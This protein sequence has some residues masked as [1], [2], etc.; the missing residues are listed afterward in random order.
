MDIR[1]IY[2]APYDRDRSTNWNSISDEAEALDSIVESMESIALANKG[3]I[4]RTKQVGKDYKLDPST[5]FTRN[6]QLSRLILRFKDSKTPE[7]I[8]IY[9]FLINLAAYEANV[10]SKVKSN[11]NLISNLRE[12]AD[13]V[14]TMFTSIINALMAESQE[15][16]DFLEENDISYEEGFIPTTIGKLLQPNSKQA[17]DNSLKAILDAIEIIAPFIP[18]DRVNELN[19][20]DVLHKN[21]NEMKGFVNNLIN[22]IAALPQANDHKQSLEILLQIEDA[23][24]KGNLDL[25][26]MKTFVR[27]LPANFKPLKDLIEKGLDK[28]DIEQLVDEQQGLPS[29]LTKDENDKIFVDVNDFINQ[30]YGQVS[31]SSKDDTINSDLLEQVNEN[32]K[33]RYFGNVANNK[34]REHLKILFVIGDENPYTL[35]DREGY[36]VYQVTKDSDLDKLL[37]LDISKIDS[38]TT[39]A[40]EQYLRLIEYTGLTFKDGSEAQ[41]KINTLKEILNP[42]PKKDI[43]EVEDIEEVQ[44]EPKEEPKEESVD[45]G[46]SSKN[47]YD[48]SGSSEHIKTILKDFSSQKIFADTL[49]DIGGNITVLGQPAKLEKQLFLHPRDNTGDFLV[50]R[51]IDGDIVFDDI[52]RTSALQA[53]LELPPVQIESFIDQISIEDVDNFKKIMETAGVGDTL[54]VKYVRG[55]RKLKEEPPQTPISKESTPQSDEFFTPQLEIPQTPSKKSKR[56]SKKSGKGLLYTELRD[57][58]AKLGNTSRLAKKQAQLV[59]SKQTIDFSKLAKLGIPLSVPNAPKLSL[60]KLKNISM[61]GRTANQRNIALDEIERRSRL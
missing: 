55:I 18:G 50:L 44:E 45:E 7:A 5:N 11:F 41:N 33:V 53:M 39:E 8:R 31:G 16:I 10:A 22:Q 12:D 9:S 32:P 28:K 57:Q 51:N 25:E 15:M 38:L 36:L 26:A 59:R 6:R 35:Q 24:L 27:L 3:I 42:P 21:M 20:E 56:K 34:A 2:R 52:P 1:S 4:K 19:R 23:I 43:E 13:D 40:I 46:S 60:A 17:Y 47:E 48:L 14:D 58:E 54:K 61:N 49:R 30:L 29:Y 37:T